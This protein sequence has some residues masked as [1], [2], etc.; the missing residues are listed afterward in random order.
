M[1]PQLSQK[2]PLSSAYFRGTYLRISPSPSLYMIR[3]HTTPSSSCAI[4]AAAA[5]SSIESLVVHSST[6]TTISTSSRFCRCILMEF[7]R[8]IYQQQSAAGAFIS[9]ITLYLSV[10]NIFYLARRSYLRKM[11]IQKL[12]KIRTTREPGVTLQLYFII[13]LVWQAFVIVFPIIEPIA[14]CLGHV[15]F[16]YSY[17][18]AGGVGI[19]FEPRHV[20]H[21]NQSQ[22]TKHQIRLDWHRFS[23]NV[24]GIGRDGF[25]HPPSVER[26]LPHI[27]IPKR[28]VKHWPWRRRWVVVKNKKE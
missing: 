1:I 18:N 8:K 15:S 19:I 9:M 17:P 5:S 4:M 23:V 21:L 14:R 20:Q 22:R 28:G 27:D 13:L 11:S 10:T 25:R 24:G 2:I 26:N 16:F 7:F 3:S 12:W 6:T